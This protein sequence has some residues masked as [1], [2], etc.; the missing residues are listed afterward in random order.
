ML[1]YQCLLHRLVPTK[2]RWSAPVTVYEHSQRTPTISFLPKSSTAAPFGRERDAQPC[3][4]PRKRRM[5]L[6]YFHVT[7]LFAGR[8]LPRSEGDAWWWGGGLLDVRCFAGSEVES[9]NAL[10][11]S[12]RAF[13]QTY[14]EYIESIKRGAEFSERSVLPT[15]RSRH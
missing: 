12:K 1:W 15:E 8:G 4:W 13:L 9:M 6:S 5:R 10:D 3:I 2:W 7:H 11:Q 14:A